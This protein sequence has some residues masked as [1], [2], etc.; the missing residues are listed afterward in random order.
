MNLHPSLRIEGGLFSPDL[1]EALAHADLP[2]QKPQDFGLPPGRNLTEEIAAVYH[3]ARSLWQIF[4]RRLERLPEEDLATSETRELWVIPFLRLLG[5][6]LQYQPRAIERD[7]LTFAF[8]HAL[9]PSPVP[10]QPT[11]VHIVG[12]RQELGR[13]APSGRPRLSPHAL[14]QEY[15]NRSEALWGLV[16]NGRI[17]RLLRD[18]TFVRRQAYVEF[19]LETLFEQERFADFVL[20]YRLL[21]R[22]RLPKDGRAEDC[23]LELYYQQSIEQGGRVREHLREGVE[24]CLIG[25]A[26]GFLS[27][28]GSAALREWIGR[29]GALAFYRQLLRLVYRFL[30]LLVS[31]ERGLMGQNPLYLES[32]GISRLRH[33]CENRAAYTDDPDL[34]LGLRALWQVFRDDKLADLLG[35]PPLNGEL[36]ASQE[37]DN[38]LI[39]NRDLLT[40]FW[41]LAFYD[42]PPRRVNYAAL[43]T[44][45]LGSVY[46]SLLDY[47][48]TVHFDSRGVPHFELAPGSERKSTGSYYTPPQ[49]V[50]EL[51][52]SALEPVI[53]QRLKGQENAQAR[54]QALLSIKVCDPACGSGHFLLAAAR[55]LGKELA[56]TRTSEDEP[57][58]EQVR[59]AIRDVVTH[60][61]YGVD[62]N[63]LAVE[64]AR[65]AL[66]LESHA[67]GKPL[68]FLEHRIKHG[69][70]LVG[71]FDL[72]IL[73]DGLPDGAFDPLE[74]DDRRL[75]AGLKR[76]NKAER[77]GQLTL[78]GWN[79]DLDLSSLAQWGQELDTIPDDTPELVHRKR[80]RYQAR[81]Q[82]PA[83]Q[84]QKDACDLWTAAFFQAFSPASPPPIT[85]AVV[86]R[87]LAGQPVPPQTLAQVQ[88]LAA[89]ACF[90]HWPLEFPEVFAK[91]GFDVVLG[92]PPFSAE[93]SK[94]EYKFLRS[95][96][97]D[98]GS[99][100]TASLFWVLTLKLTSETGRIGLVTP[101]SIIYSTRWS[102]LRNLLLPFVEKTTDLG[103]AWNDVLLEQV[104]I[105]VNKGTR[106]PSIKTQRLFS[107]IPDIVI[108][109]KE[110]LRKFDV[111]L[112]NPEPTLLEILE[113]FQKSS[114]SWLFL[115]EIL[116]TQRGKG[117]Q[118]IMRQQGEIPVIAGKD[119]APYT[120]KSISGFLTEDQIDDF[121]LFSGPKAVFQNIVAYISRP[122]PHI[123]IIGTVDYS[124][125]V[126]LDTVNIVRCPTNVL[127]PESIV[128]V[129]S[130]KLINWLVHR[131]V[132]GF[133]QRTM[134]FD[135]FALNRIFVPSKLFE[136]R[137]EIHSLANT[138]IQS[139]GENRLAA[140]SIDEL[141]FEVYELNVAS[142]K[143]ILDSF[144]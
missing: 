138:L 119:I 26:N 50:G 36:F 85:T 113:R 126:C 55:R 59:A 33:L 92:N 77:E 78:F 69:D 13:P 5:Y 64:L 94:W 58:P 23:L 32:Y 22:T 91:G 109:S 144:E 35:V 123:K 100:N 133:A 105:V 20:L 30:F 111:W 107:D 83:W 6:E 45:E 106:P 57:A 76:Q 73:K 93:L 61:I 124:N 11:P 82:D 121:G 102:K 90:F 38:A 27:H 10:E 62:K 4:Q 63:P 87:A 42:N 74:G 114:I 134:H 24:E 9:L 47:H 97:I 122:R 79:P 41:H 129:L 139:K 25:L 34:W 117:F 12:Y 125:A 112:I 128:A 39:T 49:L 3:D 8:S 108:V 48:P 7:G 51:I 40:A 71:V 56:R 53:A 103:Q 52:R 140:E 86:H 54:E 46:E 31:E 28:P 15:L 2:G 136:M 81:A 120:L 14:V 84:R 44:E 37:L 65:V 98:V 75:A 115:G 72:Q 104:L 43:D 127:S 70:S 116:S 143:S 29:E 95:L 132:Y 89:E 110:T 16:T 80:E 130:S 66:W 21:H 18:S 99:L 88:A 19:D 118:R 135:Q 142:R 96:Y 137:E 60:S 101:K 67:E 131:I 1:L 17:L 141:L 68:T